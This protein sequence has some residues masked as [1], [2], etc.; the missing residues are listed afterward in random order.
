MNF[1]NP[2]CA[3]INKFYHQVS[4]SPELVNYNYLLKFCQAYIYSARL[5]ADRPTAPKWK[6]G[7]KYEKA[8]NDLYGK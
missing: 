2:F 7:D 1:F 8:F 5:I 4:D 3:E 6:T